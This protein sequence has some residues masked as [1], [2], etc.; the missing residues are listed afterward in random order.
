MKY[1]NVLICGAICASTTQAI[2]L[3]SNQKIDQKAELVQG[4]QIKS[5]TNQKINN[6]LNNQNEISNEHKIGQ[7][8]QN[9]AKWGFLKNIVNIDQFFS[10][11]GKD[12]G[13]AAAQTSTPSSMA[14][15]NDASEGQVAAQS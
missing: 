5:L 12:G 6:Q 9:G 10:S 13:S 14:Q 11:G 3:S 2:Q 7:Q 15:Q 4:A 8:E 1:N